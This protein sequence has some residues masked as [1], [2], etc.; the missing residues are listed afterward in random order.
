MLQASLEPK[1]TWQK[2]DMVKLDK[3]IDDKDQALDQTADAVL[4][5]APGA[6]PGAGPAVPAIARRGVGVGFPGR[7]NASLHT[8]IPVYL[9]KGDIESKSLKELSGVI[10]A[11]I[12]APAKPMITVNDVLKASGKTIRGTSGGSL[13]IL[14]VSNDENKPIRIHV[15]LDLPPDVVA[16]ANVG[17]TPIIGPVAVPKA[18]PARA[19]GALPADAPPGPAKP[20]FRIAPDG[21]KADDPAPPPP[22]VV[23]RMAVTMVVNGSSTTSS[24]GSNAPNYGLTLE[25]AKGN[26]IPV[27]I[28]LQYQVVDGKATTTYFLN[29][30]MTKD[31]AEPSKLIFSGSKSVRVDVPFKLKNVP[32]P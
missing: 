25:D 2:L 24:F 11:Q 3:A 16:T 6:L 30:P 19:R 10:S 32:L 14:D 9:K 12:L 4:E 17:I 26:P 27:N 1:L 15:Q 18:A 21:K 23:A 31:G 13:K 7:V 20:A 28:G 8:S 5:A 29:V 22:P